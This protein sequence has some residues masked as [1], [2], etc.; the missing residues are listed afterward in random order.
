M[1]HVV[2]IGAGIVGICLA[3]ALSARADVTVTVLERDE[4]TPHG[5]T[6]YAPGFVGLYNDV[7]LLTDLA[8]ETAAL[9]DGAGAGFR[10]SGG[11]ELAT[12][13]Q[14]ATELE[15]RVDAA[16]S[17]GL[18]AELVGA[19]GLPDAVR[20]FVDTGRVEAAALFADDASAE[21][22]T[23]TR[24][25]RERAISR[26]ARFLA[27]QEVVGLTETG[28][29]VQVT[30]AAGESFRGDDTVLAGGVWGPGLAGLLGE[31]IPLFPVA[32]PYVHGTPSPAWTEGPFVRW[33][34]HHVYARVHGDRLGLGTY[35]H[36]P[37]PVDQQALRDG[38][39]LPWSESFDAAVDAALALLRPEARD[40][41]RHRLHRLNGVFAM[42]PDN[43]PFLGRHPRSSHLWVA[44]ALWVTHAG[45]AA[46]RLADALIDGSE[47]PPQLAVDRFDGDEAADLRDRALR[48]YR[49]IYA[50][51]AL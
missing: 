46:A 3:D 33:S 32:H 27:G 34:E 11:L 41:P 20:P 17:H 16:R 28:S 18:P 36:R 49:D 5:S 8:R 44:Q 48:L 35:D 10:R 21:A 39:S 1:R 38:A 50:H 6:A 9:Y 30:T 26:G 51:D 19:S 4:G 47:L 7:P 40:V 15:R 25:L 43:L 12:S 45:G 14:G 23:L 29:H 31:H 13:P 24:A 42:T 37:L 2:V 22:R